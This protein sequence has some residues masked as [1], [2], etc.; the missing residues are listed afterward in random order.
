[1]IKC[2]SRLPL[3]AR[4]GRRPP[5]LEP[6]EGPLLL[7]IADQTVSHTI[8]AWVYHDIGPQYG[9][10]G[11]NRALDWNSEHR[12]RLE[13]FIVDERTTGLQ[14]FGIRNGRLDGM[15]HELVEIHPPVHVLRLTQALVD[16]AREKGILPVEAAGFD[17][18]L[19]M[20]W[21][22]RSSVGRT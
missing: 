9:L 20:T 19:L 7:Y 5:G 15:H 8:P 1:M 2:A 6:H 14:A 13:S 16:H 17:G 12:F 3:H 22:S 11:S 21:C 10:V 18:T 4:S